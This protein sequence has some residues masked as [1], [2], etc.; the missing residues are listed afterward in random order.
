M[1]VPADVLALDSAKTS[2]G[3]ALISKLDMIIFNV[4]LAIDSFKYAIVDQM[5]SFKMTNKSCSIP[6]V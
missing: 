3:T 2:T 6:T 4:S 1:T 5:V